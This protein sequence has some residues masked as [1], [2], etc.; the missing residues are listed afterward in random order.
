MVYNIRQKGGD[1][2]EERLIELAIVVAGTVIGEITAEVIRSA[3][4]AFGRRR[5]H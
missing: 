4:K 3:K 2:M 1:E 5:K